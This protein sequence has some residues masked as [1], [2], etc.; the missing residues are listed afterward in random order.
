MNEKEKMLLASLPELQREHILAGH[1]EKLKQEKDI[2]KAL[3]ATH[4]EK[5]LQA[6]HWSS[7]VF[8]EEEFFC[9][10]Y[11]LFVRLKFLTIF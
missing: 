8:V 5:L 4:R 2:S 1:L 10:F 11:A 7:L 9:S 6:A 3:A